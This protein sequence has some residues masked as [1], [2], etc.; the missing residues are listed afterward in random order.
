M[1]LLTLAETAS[2][3]DRSYVSRVKLLAAIPRKNVFYVG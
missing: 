1:Q 2:G 3:T